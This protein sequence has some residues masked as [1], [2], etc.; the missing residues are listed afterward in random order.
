MFR[1]AA[2]Y[3]VLGGGSVCCFYP[4][5]LCWLASCAKV[6]VGQRNTA[7]PVL[8]HQ[9]HCTSGGALS[10]IGLPVYGGSNT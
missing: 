10:I 2:P 4:R 9:F 8:W 6:L 3:P 5:V 7:P 1:G